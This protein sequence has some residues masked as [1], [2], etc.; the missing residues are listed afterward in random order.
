MEAES[1]G[2]RMFKRRKAVIFGRTRRWVAKNTPQNSTAFIW[3]AQLGRTS[4][5]LDL[6]ANRYDAV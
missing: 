3:A 1:W 5:R 6:E 2:H 4:R